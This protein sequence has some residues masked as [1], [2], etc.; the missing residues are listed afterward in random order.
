VR[1]GTFLENQYKGN[2]KFATA[3]VG[4]KY[5]IFAIDVCYLIPF[6]QRHPLE[7]TLRFTLTFMLKSFN[8]DQIKQQGKLNR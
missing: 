4:V 3:G 5:I 7:N 1:A 2:R 8:K 6:T